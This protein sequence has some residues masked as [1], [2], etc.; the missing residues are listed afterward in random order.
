MAVDPVL[1]QGCRV[2]FATACDLPPLAGPGNGGLAG[3]ILAFAGNDGPKTQLRGSH[4][5]IVITTVF[6]TI[7]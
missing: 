2:A 6:R 3:Y 7:G 1:Q 5:L 4:M